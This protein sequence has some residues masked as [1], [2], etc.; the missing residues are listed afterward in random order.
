M[1]IGLVYHPKTMAPAIAVGD[2]LFRSIEDLVAA[3]PGLAGEGEGG[4]AA[5]AAAYN[6]LARR[7]AYEVIED[8]AAFEAAYRA[9][10]AAEDAGAAWSQ[11]RPRLSDFGM[12]DFERLHAPV[13]AGGTLTFFARD[14]LTGLAYRVSGPWKLPEGASYEPMR[15]AARR[16]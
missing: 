9:A 16:G 10:H 15:L 6:H 1:N 7:D 13:L 3:N 4:A 14:A 5:L 8:P 2:G 12:P 11:D